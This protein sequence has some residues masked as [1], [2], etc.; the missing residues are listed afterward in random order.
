MTSTKQSEQTEPLDVSF[1]ELIRILADAW[2]GVVAITGVSVV[3]ALV[4]AY[5]MRPVYKASTLLT[6]TAADDARSALSRLAGQLGPL[7]N[8]V[9]GMD[10][11]GN[12]YRKEVW[13][14]TLR[15]RRLTEEFIRDRNLLPILFADRW[16]PG[17]NQWKLLNGESSAPSMEEAVELFD[18]DIRT[19]SEDRRTGLLTLSI[20][21]F[22]RT[23]AADWANDLISRA[24]DYIRNRTI[25]ES[26]ESISFL[27]AE[28]KK[29][30][31]VELQQVIYSVIESKIS[32]IMMANV[33]KEYAFTVIDPAVAPDATSHVRPRKGLAA[34]IG[35]FVG[36][37]I[38][39]MYAGICRARNLRRQLGR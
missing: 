24:N 3:V 32:E 8:L 11:G 30:N 20:E 37:A 25:K 14:A 10:L 22:D 23:L 9:G 1:A 2:K 33:R 5:S 12:A 36:G 15:S 27:E 29:T 31:V 18:E 34:L 7:T 6:V 35:L 17:T 19:V 13:V 4:I 26:R 21:W 28:S 39:A 38:G 16:D